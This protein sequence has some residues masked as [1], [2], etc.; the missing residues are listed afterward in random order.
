MGKSMRRLIA[1]DCAGDTLV[2]TLDDAAGTTGLLIVSGGNEVRA[3][4]HRG[5]SMLAE[6]LSATGTPVF[7]YDRRG[8][9]DS[10]GE[11]RGFLN[12]AE[13][14]VSAASAF[15]RSAPHVTHVVGFGNCDGASALALYG[16][17]AGID[18]IVL[19]NPFVAPSPDDLPPAPAIRAHYASRL[20]DP[21]T[22][23]RLVRGDLN[24]L[25]L[26]RGLWRIVNTR[27]T[28][29]EDRTVRAVSDWNSNAKIILAR[30][31]HTA[32]AWRHA[33]R[34]LPVRTTIIATGSHSF[35]G[36]D[37]QRRLEAAIR[38]AL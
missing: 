7:R 35:A 8:I 4:A 9:G 12:G 37:D 1:F 31:D 24:I 32:V 26:A 30:D 10:S 38:E 33:A 29:T 22:I 28:S 6:R 3:G 17:S 23:D 5:M 15:R 20:R 14:L 11:N 21:R 18:R 2:G 19:A 13:D 16:Q 27:S 36:V 34:H 25:R